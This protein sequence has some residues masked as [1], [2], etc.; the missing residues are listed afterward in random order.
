MSWLTPKMILLVVAGI[1]LVGIFSLAQEANR[2]WQYRQEVAQLQKKAQ[3]LEAKVIEL[4]NL[5]T[6]FRTEEYQEKLARE[7]LNF[8]A[9]GE[10]VVL[11]PRDHE[12]VEVTSQVIESEEK[13][14]S[15]PELW[16]RVFFVPDNLS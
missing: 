4:D 14:Y 15:N 5:N 10:Q 16:W 6:Y 11:V 3:G 13:N 8:R 12:E 2:R 7:K 1:V 9:E